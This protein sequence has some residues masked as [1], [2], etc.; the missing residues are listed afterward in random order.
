M[1]LRPF[2]NDSIGKTIGIF[3][4]IK[5]TS[6]FTSNTL[7]ITIPQMILVYIG[8]QN[9]YKQWLREMLREKLS[10]IKEVIQN[11]CVMYTLGDRK[12]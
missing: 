11:K 12:I 6:G 10:E 5:G 9:A 1:S 7:L 8:L 4:I 3:L 2:I